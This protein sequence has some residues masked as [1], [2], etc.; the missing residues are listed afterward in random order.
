MGF[1]FL[2]FYRANI[3]FGQVTGAAQ[4]WQQPAGFGGMLASHGQG[5]PDPVGK[6]GIARAAPWL[7]GRLLSL[8]ILRRG[9]QQ[10]FRRGTTRSIQ[11]GEGGGDLFSAM[12]GQNR[13]NEFLFVRRHRV[14]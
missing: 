6:I 5:K 13:L 10:F 12:L 11:S 9:V 7:F 3:S 4:H 1:F 2:D 8:P 14:A